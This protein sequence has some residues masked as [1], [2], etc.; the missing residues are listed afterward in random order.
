MFRCRL[1]GVVSPGA[2]SERP[3]APSALTVCGSIRVKAEA[4]EQVNGYGC[5]QLKLRRVFWTT[6]GDYLNPEE[7]VTLDAA[8]N[9]DGGQKGHRTVDYR[10]VSR[11]ADVL[12]CLQRRM[13]RHI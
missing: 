11:D 10:G 4:E 9:Q 12:S 1:H 5:R 6:C 3:S 7:T 8:T 2:R 13:E